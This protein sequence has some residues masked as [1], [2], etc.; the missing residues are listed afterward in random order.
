MKGNPAVPGGSLTSKPTWS[1]A[2]GCPTTSAFLLS[3]TRSGIGRTG[4]CKEPASLDR[5]GTE[6]IARYGGMAYLVDCHHV[7]RRGIEEIVETVF[8]GTKSARQ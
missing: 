7:S 1:N 5:E 3:A 8:V 6:P 2:F 4:S